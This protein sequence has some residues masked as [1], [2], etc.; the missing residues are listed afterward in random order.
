MEPNVEIK[1][2]PKAVNVPAATTTTSSTA[3]RRRGQGHICP[4][5]TATHPKDRW[6]MFYVYMFIKNFTNLIA[7]IPSFLTIEECVVIPFIPSC[8]FW[9]DKAI[10]VIQS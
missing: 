4:P 9:V 7:D 10:L 2:E 5:P 3:P 8:F 6:D 1:E